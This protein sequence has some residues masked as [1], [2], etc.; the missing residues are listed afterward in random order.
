MPGTSEQGV[1]KDDLTVLDAL[2]KRAER[3]AM[4]ELFNPSPLTS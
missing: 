3:E 1:L 2:Q 4:I